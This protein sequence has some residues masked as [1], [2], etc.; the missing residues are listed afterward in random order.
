M[1]RIDENGPAIGVGTVAREQLAAALDRDGVVAAM[2]FGSQATGK[3]GPLSDIDVAVWADSTLG[4]SE[5]FDLRLALMAEAVRVLNTD[6][7]DLVVLNDAPPLLQHRA[8]RDSVRL[9]D[10]D[11][12][13]RIRLETRA[14]LDYLDTKPLREL[15]GAAALERLEEG[16]FGRP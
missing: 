7:V 3:A 5:R 9:I 14:I 8:L 6:E 13:K 1:T 10:R 16:R 2:L 11:P 4:R 12:P 15:F